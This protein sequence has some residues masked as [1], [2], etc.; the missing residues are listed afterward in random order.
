[1]SKAKRNKRRIAAK[2]R[3]AAA[4]K[5]APAVENAAPI[6]EKTVPV[7]SAEAVAEAAPAKKRRFTRRT[8]VKVMFV[9]A[10]IFIM[11]S[12]TYS[13]FTSSSRAT[14]DGL[15]IDVIDPNN[16]TA[17]GITISG[18]ANSLSGNGTS[19]FKPVFK[20]SYETVISGSEVIKA[21][22]K[23]IASYS[24][25]G[26][27]VESKVA[28]ADNLLTVDFSLSIAGEHEL[29]MTNGTSITAADGSPDFLKGAVRVA[30]L[31]FVPDEAVAETESQTEAETEAETEAGVSGKYVTELVWIPDVLTNKDGE[32]RL[33]TDYIIATAESRE[34]EKSFS[35]SAESG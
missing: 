8:L 3:S 25:S 27:D 29:Y 18:A 34:A 32:D 28:N 15:K 35:V 10:V 19:F 13:W 11:I 2:K 12:L 17:D 30:V 16:L 21:Y 6:A 22:R 23:V 5:L 33:D 14:V 24:P 31:K 9:A 20:D 4:K 26:D 1:M 7:D